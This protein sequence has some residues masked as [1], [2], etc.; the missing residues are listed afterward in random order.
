MPGNEIKDL[1]K[2]IRVI[3][4]LIIKNSVGSQQLQIDYNRDKCIK[5]YNK[6]KDLA[7]KYNKE[8]SYLKK[9]AP[10]N[11]QCRNLEEFINNLPSELLD[12]IKWDDDHKRYYCQVSDYRM[13]YPLN[14]NKHTC[15]L[16][17]CIYLFEQ[18]GDSPHRYLDTSFTIKKDDI[19]FD[20][21]A[22]EGLFTLQHLDVISEAYVFECDESWIEALKL[23]FKGVDK[24]HIIP[25]YVGS[26]TSE[27]TVRLDDYLDE[28]GDRGIFI[29]MDVEGSEESVLQGMSQLLV[30]KTDLRCA[31]CAYHKRDDDV[32]LLKYIDGMEYNY[33]D[34]YMLCLDGYQKPPYFRRGVIRAYKK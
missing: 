27:T 13:Y 34:G 2:R 15:I 18:S 3:P 29:K 28:V 11:M 33:S 1:I 21:G 25:K 7:D 19:L 9:K 16:Y 6:H 26:Y 14:L 12:N 17:Y 30:Q 8:L 4:Y 32:R 5:Y 24:V 22:A 23:T 20:I 31:I 10:S